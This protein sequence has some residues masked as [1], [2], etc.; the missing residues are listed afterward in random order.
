MAN[1]SNAALLAA[2][3]RRQLLLLQE[4]KLASVEIQI[5]AL[6]NRYNFPNDN[7]LNGKTITKF[8]L[9]DNSTGDV[10]APSGA[11]LI[12]NSAVI[13]ANFTV[14][15]D[16]DA[17]ILDVPLVYF[18]ESWN[19]G[20]RRTRDV[21]IEGFNPGTTYVNFPNIGSVAIGQSILFM[22]EYIDC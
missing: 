9:P 18:Q 2:A 15:R 17:V 5:T 20:D 11:P 16:S 22:V 1:K 12:T 4:R 14:R 19:G 21:W 10:E 13:A 6:V 8:W 7:F 3:E